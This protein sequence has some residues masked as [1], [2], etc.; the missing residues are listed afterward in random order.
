MKKLCRI[1][2]LLLAGIFVCLTAV[3]ASAAPLESAAP[4]ALSAPAYLLV[5]AD[6]GTVI[7]EKNADE[8]RQAASVTKLMT[9]LLVLEDI[10]Q[11]R[12][13]L[14]DSVTVSKNAA[15]TIGSTALLDAG[16]VYPLEDL[17]KAT[18]IASAND[19]AVA[20]AEY[21]GGQRAGLRGRG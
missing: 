13:S 15:A 9:L 4:I 10:G 18:V 21:I 6:T 11:G 8:R 19:G 7:F 16:S 5:E 20:L 1:P 17:L 3:P 2:A 14:T 12:L